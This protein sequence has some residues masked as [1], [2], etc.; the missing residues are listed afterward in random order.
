MIWCE[1]IIELGWI[2]GVRV[3]ACN[4]Y[5]ERVAACQAWLM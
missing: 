4:Y 2:Y 1:Y 3:E 5:A